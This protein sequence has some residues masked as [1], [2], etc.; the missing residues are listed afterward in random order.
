MGG[1]YFDF[2]IERSKLD[3]YKAKMFE[4]FGDRENAIKFYKK[5]ISNWRNGDKDYMNFVDA[6]AQLAKL[7]G[8][9]Q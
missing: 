2:Y 9:R 1:D 4:H 6:K 3:Y 5:T 7:N 8:G